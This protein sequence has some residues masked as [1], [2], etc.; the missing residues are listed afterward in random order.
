[1]LTVTGCVLV[2]GGGVPVGMPNESS[3]GE[4]E[5]DVTGSGGTAKACFKLKPGSKNAAKPTIE[6]TNFFREFMAYPFI[7]KA[8]RQKPKREIRLRTKQRFASFPV[9][10]SSRWGRL[11]LYVTENQS[12]SNGLILLRYQ[13]AKASK[14]VEL[15]GSGFELRNSGRDIAK[16]RLA[17]IF[18]IDGTSL[19]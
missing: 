13:L 1:M 18:G 14:S 4:T 5:T 12:I 6:Q 19:L 11:S 10:A 17:F 9:W 16:P 15:C 7:S 3:P 2:S 8:C